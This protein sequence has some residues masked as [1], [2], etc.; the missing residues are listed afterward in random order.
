[1]KRP[2]WSSDEIEALRRRACVL[3]VGAKIQSVYL[4]ASA[5]GIA[6]SARLAFSPG[7]LEARLKLRPDE[8][9]IAAQSIGYRPKSILDHIR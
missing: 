9:V 8:R 4:A 1:M 2:E 7:K 6:C 3:D 5:L